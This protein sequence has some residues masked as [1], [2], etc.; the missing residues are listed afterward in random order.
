[1]ELQDP[2]TGEFL[3]VDTASARVRRQ[4]AA[5]VHERVRERE[6][7]FRRMDAQTLEIRTDRPY[8]DPL[9]RFFHKRELR[10]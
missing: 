4:Y 7:M 6:T 1:M 3:L 9:V 8:V 10:R 2:E 5:S